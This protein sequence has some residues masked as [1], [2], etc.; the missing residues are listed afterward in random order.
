MG[1]GAA[2]SDLYHPLVTTHEG[3]TVNYV[4]ARHT[5]SIRWKGSVVRLTEGEV[6]DALDP[7]VKENIG[8]FLPSPPLVRTSGRKP[9]RADARPVEQATRA[10]GE[11]RKTV[12]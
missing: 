2:D 12:R 1:G 8:F 7:F 9:V 4:Y 5:C 3:A 10:P 11:K 6:W